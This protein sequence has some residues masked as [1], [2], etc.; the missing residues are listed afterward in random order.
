MTHDAAIY[1]AMMPLALIRN[2]LMHSAW[3]RY[4]REV[5]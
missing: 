5:R 1:E 3:T 4:E 2:A